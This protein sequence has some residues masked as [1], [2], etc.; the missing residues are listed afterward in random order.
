MINFCM[1]R[2]AV[3]LLVGGILLGGLLPFS[4]SAVYA[5]DTM[6]L[7]ANPDSIQINQTSSVTANLR[8]GL[9][10]PISG[11]PISFTVSF[12]PGTVS[13]TPSTTGAD[14]N[15]NT[16]Y[17]APSSLSGSPTSVLVRGCTSDSSLCS[18]ALIRVWE[19]SVATSITSAAN[20]NPIGKGDT[21]TVTA[22][23][24]D[25]FMA[26]MGNVTVTFSI[27][28]GPGSISPSQGTTNSN[29]KTS[30]TYT[31][32]TQFPGG[33]TQATIRSCIVGG[34]GACSDTTI[35]VKK[36]L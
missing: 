15:A 7:S 1:G 19:S 29:G 25:Q 23:V 9:G 34:S 4:T 17:S 32:P 16:T 5:A 11:S 31:A 3:F 14:G 30:T 18:T 27:V 8:D 33:E 10:N 36:N 22:T 26:P 6:S 20:P 24:K 2:K 28:S 35:T 21:S 12:G 13:P